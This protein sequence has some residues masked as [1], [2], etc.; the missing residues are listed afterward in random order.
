[1][2][3]ANERSRKYADLAYNGF[4]CIYCRYAIVSY[5]SLELLNQKFNFPFYGLFNIFPEVC[6]SSMLIKTPGFSSEDSFEPEAAGVASS[7]PEDKLENGENGSG[8]KYFYKILNE[9]SET[10]NNDVP[11]SLGENQF[12]ANKRVN[13]FFKFPFHP[14]QNYQG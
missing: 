1:M 13:N 9:N 4:R 11:R 2:R 6:D 7:T 14:N 12:D 8:V 5:K 10:M 3:S